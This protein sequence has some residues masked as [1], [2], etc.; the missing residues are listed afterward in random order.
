MSLG[1]TL[2]VIVVY[3]LAAARVTRLINHD[4]VLDPLRLM[5]DRRA[6]TAR[7]AAEEAG[8][9]EQASIA[10]QY[11]RRMGRWNLLLEFLGCPWCV[12]WW[13]ALAGAVGVVAVLGWPWWA[14][15]CVAL[16]ASYLIGVAAPLSA[17][18]DIVI[19]D[20]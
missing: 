3:L 11:R 17:G 4:T 20:P 18:E 19:V 14:A 16:A 8:N 9:A 15:V 7:L 12:G 5:I 2:L 13:V 6:Q 10:E 1:H